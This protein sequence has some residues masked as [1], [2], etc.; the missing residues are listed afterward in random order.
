MR[1][2]Q[3]IALARRSVLGT[4]RQPEL[5][6]PSL[7]FPLFFAALSTASFNKSI[8]VL[9]GFHHVRTF[10]DFQ[11]AA[12]VVQGVLFGCT[13]GGNDMAVDIQDGFFDR[14]LT[15]PVS[16]SSILVG[17]LAGTAALGAVQAMVF[18]GVLVAFGASI[19]GG[20]AAVVAIVLISAV[21]AL[22][23]GGLAV[24]LALRTGSAEAVQAS[25]PLFFIS[26]FMSSAFFPRE[27]M[28]GWFKVVATVNPLSWLVEAMR[29]L[30]I[31]GFDVAS[32]LRALAV[33][34]VLCVFSI[35]LSTMALRARVAQA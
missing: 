13:G 33:V 10:L 23:V 11:L 4:I 20:L 19:R 27:T 3:A 14:L 6:M 28:H 1:R 29:H 8:H 5:I 17:R 26:L 25:F 12:T 15:S 2:H 7:F 35:S 24:A 30:V 34:A 32:V 22:G 16:R 9:P 18:M 31:E 21:L